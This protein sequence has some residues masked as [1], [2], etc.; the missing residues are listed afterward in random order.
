MTA[1]LAP[2]RAADRSDVLAVIRSMYDSY[3]AGDRAG[4]D[5]CLADGFTMFDSA[6]RGLI[7]GLAELDVVRAGR[8]S[9]AGPQNERLST[10]DEHVEFRGDL[11][12][13]AY[14]LRVESDTDSGTEVELVRNTAV[15]QPAGDSWAIVHLH[16]DVV[17]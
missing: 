9:P 15:L 14:W 2:D 10:H 7:H 8:P 4:I 1:D 17:A 11:A 3:M 13:A 6:H 16:E 5:A 12:I